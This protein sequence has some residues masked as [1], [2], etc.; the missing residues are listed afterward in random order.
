MYYMYQTIM[1]KHDYKLY[2][3][4]IAT[5]ADIGSSFQWE[6]TTCSLNLTADLPTLSMKITCPSTPPKL[7]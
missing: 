3:L 4:V 5:M 2:I 6:P 1:A 7:R